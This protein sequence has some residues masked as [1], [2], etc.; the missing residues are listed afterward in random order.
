MNGYFKTIGQLIR[1]LTE[2]MKATHLSPNDTAS[3]NFYLISQSTHLFRLSSKEADKLMQDRYKGCRN[4]KEVK[5]EL[6]YDYC[7]VKL[8]EF[9]LSRSINAYKNY[10]LSE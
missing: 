9:S 8:N 10:I 2:D 1:Y 4:I 6:L 5:E 3:N 7:V